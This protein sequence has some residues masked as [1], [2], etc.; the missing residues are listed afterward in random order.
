VT[1]RLKELGYNVI[2][3]NNASSASDTETFR[4]I[5]AEIYWKLRQAFIDGKIKIYDLER[6]IKDLSSIKYDFQSN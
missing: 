2:P 6:V 5:K 4:D 3:V 1:D